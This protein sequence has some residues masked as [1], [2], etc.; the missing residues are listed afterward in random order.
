MSLQVLLAL[1]N[2]A[3]SKYTGITS[4]RSSEEKKETNK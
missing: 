1:V 4:Q 2:D 3:A